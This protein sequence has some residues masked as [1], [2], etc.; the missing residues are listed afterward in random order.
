M[1]SSP[2]S[3]R[4]CISSLFSSQPPFVLTSTGSFLCS[5]HASRLFPQETSYCD[6]LSDEAVQCFAYTAN[7]V[8]SLRSKMTS[9]QSLDPLSESILVCLQIRVSEITTQCQAYYGHPQ[10]VP[11]ALRLPAQQLPVQPSLPAQSLPQQ[12]SAANWS[13]SVCGHSNN[14]S[15]K[16]CYRCRKPQGSQAEIASDVTTA[17]VDISLLSDSPCD[18]SGMWTCPKQS[19]GRRNHYTQKKCN[20]G[21]TN[22][23]LIDV[24]V[25]DEP[26]MPVVDHSEVYQPTNSDNR[27]WTCSDCNYEYN[28][29]YFDTCTVCGKPNPSKRKPEEVKARL[30][31]TVWTCLHCRYEYNQYPSTVCQRC[32][33]SQTNVEER[34]AE[35]R[36]EEEKV[37]LQ[38]FATC[39]CCRTQYP[40]TAFIGKFCPDC[41]TMGRAPGNSFLP[42]QQPKSS[43]C[44]E[45]GAVNPIDSLCCTT[46]VIQG[47]KVCPHCSQNHSQGVSECVYPK[48][49]EPPVVLEERKAEE[50]QSSLCSKC[51]NGPR[52][53]DNLCRQCSKPEQTPPKPEQTPPKPAAIPPEN[54]QIQSEYVQ[55]PRQPVQAPLASIK[56]FFCMKC[57]SSNCQ[58]PKP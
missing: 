19:C 1:A 43:T 3:C 12:P 33:V 49:R 45:C 42:L 6:L 53:V 20:C 36:K 11:A 5:Q 30:S 55:S 25:I 29:G 16:I 18:D 38:A 41:Y 7:Y 54:G 37:P 17:P 13:C 46:C 51:N 22:L 24:E 34:K 52:E 26:P 21:Y 2:F 57:K 8:Q 15:N 50:K 48:P 44:V 27:P 23:G 9:H 58:C 32:K 31:S 14:P 40:A 56:R 10:A 39:E 35:K 4:L 28:M 47:K